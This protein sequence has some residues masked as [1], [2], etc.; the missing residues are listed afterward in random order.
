MVDQKKV[1]RRG[2][3]FQGNICKAA[4]RNGNIKSFQAIF[5]F[6]V[7]FRFKGSGCFCA[8]DVWIVW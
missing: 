5:L 7:Y 2:L 6:C 3:E 1:F 4:Y 8:Y